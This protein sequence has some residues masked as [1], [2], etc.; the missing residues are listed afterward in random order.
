MKKITILMFTIAS[1]I[2]A[3]KSTKEGKD[4][5]KVEVATKTQQQNETAVSFNG[6]K[7]L[8]FHTNQRCIS[9][10]AIENLTKEVIAEINSDSI[11][12]E[13]INISDKANE[14][15]ADK[16]EVTWS[17]LILD[18][19]KNINNL[20][21]MAFSYAKNQPEVFKKNLKAEIEKYLK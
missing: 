18:N 12:L 1:L 7:V 3:C 9:C 6:L 2:I 17:S 4:E 10:R 20:T 21:K 8:S 15:L 16:Y 11:R 14:K 13:V 19:G 5:K